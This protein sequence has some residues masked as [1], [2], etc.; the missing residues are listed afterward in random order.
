M[1]FKIATRNICLGLPH[2]NTPFKQLILV[3]KIDILSVQET[4]IDKKLWPCY[5]NLTQSAPG[6][7]SI[8]DQQ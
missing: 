8:S 6:W 7:K 2:K 4:E 5:A 1:V 3:K